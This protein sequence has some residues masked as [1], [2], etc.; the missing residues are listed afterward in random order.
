MRVWYILSRD[1][2]LGNMHRRE[3]NNISAQLLAYIGLHPVRTSYGII[4]LFLKYLQR[5]NGVKVV[6]NL[7]GKQGDLSDVEV[8]AS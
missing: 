4:S 8:L 5:C 3:V 7:Q 1:D 2:L 6:I